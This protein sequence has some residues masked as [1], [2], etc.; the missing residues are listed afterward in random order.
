MPHLRQPSI[1]EQEARFRALL[2]GDDD[3][4]LFG[5]GG[6]LVFAIA[7]HE[8]FRYQFVWIPGHSDFAVQ[9]VVPVSHVFCL[10]VDKDEYAVDVRG[11]RRVHEVLDCFGGTEAVLTSAPE[12][13]AWRSDPRRGIYAEPWFH[14]AAIVRARTRI[15]RHRSYFDGTRKESIPLPA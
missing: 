1:E 11:T 2:A 14:D 13:L 8:I 10:L 7:L 12:L 6:C 4:A 15:E 9:G 3:V 5:E